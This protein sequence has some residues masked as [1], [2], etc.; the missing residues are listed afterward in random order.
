LLKK[1]LMRKGEREERGKGE[2]NEGRRERKKQTRE[3]R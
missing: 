2:N 3:G 1:K